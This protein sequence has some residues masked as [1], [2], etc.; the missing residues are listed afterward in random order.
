M[1]TVDSQQ[2]IPQA[3]RNP[4]ADKQVDS[5]V[6]YLEEDEAGGELLLAWHRA[7]STFVVSDSKSFR[8]QD[9]SV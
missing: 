8:L 2:S 6:D 5:K 3:S 1:T 4:G 9:G 7:P